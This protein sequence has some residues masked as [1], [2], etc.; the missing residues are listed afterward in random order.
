MYNW[1]GSEPN[2]DT[3]CIGDFEPEFFNTQVHELYSRLTSH[4]EYPELFRKAF[5]IRDINAL[6]YQQLKTRI[7]HAI[8]QYMRTLISAN[9]RFDSARIG[10]IQL[11]PDE[12]EGMVIFFS[13]KGDCFHCHAQP[14]FNDNRLHNNGLSSTFAGFDKGHALVTAQDKDLGLFVT[15][16]LRNIAQTAPYMHDGRFGTLEEVIDFYNSGVKPSATLDPVM[17]KR[18]N[19]QTLDLTDEEKRQLVAFLKTLTDQSFIR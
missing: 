11:S 15:P 5:N 17:Y 18:K 13:E 4:P 1:E 12:H 8:S 6:T 7:S 3:L 9:S 2:L 16:T 19:I 14:L 10:Y